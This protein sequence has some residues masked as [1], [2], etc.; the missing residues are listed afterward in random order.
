M[1]IVGGN[2]GAQIDTLLLLHS[3]TVVLDQ[4]SN[5]IQEVSPPVSASSIN[6]LNQSD[7]ESIIIE[8][9][10]NFPIS[11]DAKIRL[12]PMEEISIGLEMKAIKSVKIQAIEEPTVSGSDADIPIKTGPLSTENS[13]LISVRFLGERIQ[14]GNCP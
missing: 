5:S 10:P 1:A 11:G 14:T 4:V 13:H 8:I 2:S 3:C 7:K 9:V 6:V 12:S